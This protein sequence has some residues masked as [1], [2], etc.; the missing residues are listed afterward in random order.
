MEQNCAILEQVGSKFLSACKFTPEIKSDGF[1][2]SNY[3]NIS[4]FHG[5]SIQ[6][7]GCESNLQMFEFPRYSFYIC[8]CELIEIKRA[9]SDS[10]N[11]SV[12][13]VWVIRWIRK[14]LLNCFQQINDTITF[15]TI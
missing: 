12:K 15:Y 7:P 10:P 3:V 11:I 14:Y 4:Y 6:K 13:S 5:I 9:T 2:C 8:L 1:T